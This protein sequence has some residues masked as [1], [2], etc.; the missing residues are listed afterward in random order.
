M[1]LHDCEVLEAVKSRLNINQP[2]VVLQI[3][4]ECDVTA[5][6]LCVW[7]F[8]RVVP[9]RQNSWKLS[10]KLAKT[11]KK[12]KNIKTISFGFDW[13]IQLMFAKK[14][15]WVRGGDVGNSMEV[16]EE[17]EGGGQP[18]ELQGPVGDGGRTLQRC[19][20][21]HHTCKQAN[22]YTTP[23]SNHEIEH[24]HLSNLLCQRFLRLEPN[25][26]FASAAM[27]WQRWTPARFQQ[28]ETSSGF[29]TKNM[30]GEGSG[31]GGNRRF[32]AA[33]RRWNYHFIFDS[34]L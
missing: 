7:R 6:R 15:W 30:A 19:S 17:E 5:S 2:E 4:D 12:K 11:C 3:H 9:P 14:W 33:V 23:T 1:G 32:L 27:W 25:Q 18:W 20:Q 31:A 8:G 24:S 22:T 29:T 26:V 28:Q 34:S 10:L 13:A 21:L 16:E